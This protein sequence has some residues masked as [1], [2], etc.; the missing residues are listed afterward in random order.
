MPKPLAEITGL[1]KTKKSTLLDKI[2]FA[3]NTL[4]RKDLVK[5]IFER[6]VIDRKHS[7]RVKTLA[8]N[9]FDLTADES[10]KPSHR[11]ILKD[12]ALLH[13]AGKFIT[14]GTSHHKQSSKLI[15][16]SLESAN[17]LSN[18]EKKELKNAAKIA[19]HHKGRLKPQKLDQNELKLVAILRM[20]DSFSKLGAKASC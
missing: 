16:K 9:I 8:K 5:N 2:N 15:K 11:R 13:D 6:F 1:L 19:R 14:S 12:A 4:Q 17:G 3:P 18:K 10:L 20:A 7:K